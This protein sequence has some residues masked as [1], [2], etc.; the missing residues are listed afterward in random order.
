M[1]PHSASLAQPPGNYPVYRDWPEWIGM[2]LPNYQNMWLE[3]RLEGRLLRGGAIE[4]PT[5]VVRPEWLWNLSKVR[6]VSRVEGLLVSK[7]GIQSPWCGFKR[8]WTKTSQPTGFG[9]SV[10]RWLSMNLF[11]ISRVVWSFVFGQSWNESSSVS[12][13]W[14]HGCLLVLVWLSFSF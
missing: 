8:A 11:L 5:M 4:P 3:E 7:P 9:E 12:L 10:T 1:G 13:G 2:K 6:F 14:P